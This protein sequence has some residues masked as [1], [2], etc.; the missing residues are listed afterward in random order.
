MLRIQ[1]KTKDRVIKN[2]Y[3]Y[4]YSLLN[5]GYFCKYGLNIMRYLL[6]IHTWSNFISRKDR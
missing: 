3:F 1:L 2:G 5:I 6:D 4:K